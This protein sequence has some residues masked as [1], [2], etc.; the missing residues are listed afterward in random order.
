MGKAGG[1]LYQ[2]TKANWIY[3]GARAPILVPFMKTSQGKESWPHL[4]EK[5]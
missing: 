5:L 2:V 3:V 4:S 1:R